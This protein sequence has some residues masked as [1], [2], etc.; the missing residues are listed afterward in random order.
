MSESKNFMN[1][2]YRS[3]VVSGLTVGYAMLGK[4]LLR[5]KIGDPSNADLTEALKLAGA[6]TAAM[7]T[8]DYLIKAKILPPSV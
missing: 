3:A 4:R 5:V 1:L 2:A 8:Q 7:V 6:V